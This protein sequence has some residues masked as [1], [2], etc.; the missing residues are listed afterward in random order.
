MKVFITGGTGFVGT[1]LTD[2]LVHAGLNVTITERSGKSPFQNNPKVNTRV[3]DT[4]YPGDWQSQIATSDVVINLAGKNIF[5]RWSNKNKQE[6][7]ESRLLTTQNIVDAIPDDSNT[8]LLST[9]AAGFY[10]DRHASVLKEDAEPGQG[11]LSDLCFKWETEARRAEAKNARVV[12]MRFGMVLGEGGGA[13]KMMV[14]SFRFFV[15]GSLGSGKNWVPWIHI[16]DLVAAI[17]YIIDTDT[18]TGPVNF[19]AP[20]SVPHKVFVK[21]IGKTLCR[22]SFFSIPTFLA[23]MVMGELGKELMS[24]QRMVPETLINSGF[25]FQFGDIEH[26]LMDL[27]GN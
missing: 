12:L 13:L 23:R 15:G 9:S 2:H 27:L 16:A 17:M 22:P 7:V 18:I 11:F 20:A 6:I 5:T 10:G 14:P 25:R 21:A 24:S 19:C 8:L 1:I 3:C 26:A 4:R